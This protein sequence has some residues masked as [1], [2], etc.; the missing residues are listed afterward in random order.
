MHA[1]LT[2]C[3]RS[4]YRPVVGTLTGRCLRVTRRSRC[5]SWAPELGGRDPTTIRRGQRGCRAGRCTLRHR[6]RRWARPDRGRTAEV[7]SLRWRVVVSIDPVRVC[8]LRLSAVTRPLLVGIQLPEVEWEVPF[9]E[10]IRMAQTRSSGSTGVVGDICSTPPSARVGRGRCGRRGR[11]RGIDRARAARPLVASA[12]FHEDDAAS[13]QRQSTGYRAAADPRA[14]IRMERA[15]YR[16]FGLP[17][18]TASVA[19][20]GVHDH[21]HTARHGE[22]D[23]AASYYRAERCVLHPRA[24]RPGGRV[25][26]GLGPTPD[27]LDHAPYVDAW[28]CGGRLCNTSCRLRRGES[29]GRSEAL[30][31]G[32]AAERV[33]NLRRV[34]SASGAAGDR[35]RYAIACRADT[36]QRRR[37]RDQSSILL[38]SA[39][40]RAAVR[41]SDH[42]RFDR[43]VRTGTRAPRSLIATQRELIEEMQ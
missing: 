14:R 41:R 37:S 19:L 35:G 3:S 7:R 13:R 18:I 6:V 20:R 36:R 4:T 33:R 32:R 25:D 30:D 34:H 10:L 28:T 26:G 27:A 38:T 17:S 43:M 21:S 15:C 9:P 16:A 5:T 11:A 42:T 8:G 2:H 12:G 1:T 29:E 23:F 24:S 39:L 40:T 31:F 22:I